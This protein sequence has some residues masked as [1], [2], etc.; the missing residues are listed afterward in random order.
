MKKAAR[1]AYKP[2]VIVLV[3]L[4]QLC[5]RE[6]G[7]VHL[8]RLIRGGVFDPVDATVPAVPTFRV[9]VVAML[10][11][12]PVDHIHRAVRAVLKIDGDV[13]GVA[14]EEHVPAGMNGVEAR[15]EPL[16]DLLIDLV[17][18]EIVGEKAAAEFGR[19]IVAQINH[20]ADVRVTAVDQVAAG[21]AR[22]A[23][24]MI[25]P[26]RRQEVIAETGKV[27]GRIRDDERRVVRIR[28]IPKMTAMNDV[29]RQSHAPIAA[30]VRHENLSA[31]VVIEAPLVAAAVGEY[32]ELG[33]Q[34][35]SG[36]C[37][38]TCSAR[39]VFS[40]PTRI[41]AGARDLSRRNV[42]TAQTRP[43]KFQSLL[44]SPAPLRTE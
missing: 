44:R 39:Y 36:F 7:E 21:F 17:A 24:S 25:V 6:T 15:T 12:I 3:Q 32:F 38:P 19:P 30:A 26:R 1:G 2:L 33:H 43:Q 8:P 16:V 11:V 27:L 34:S 28:L 40:A 37:R 22:A 4:R 10:L 35:V 31:L 23:G 41:A 5:V 13:S 9:R 14:A 42:S 20:R 18:M 29:S